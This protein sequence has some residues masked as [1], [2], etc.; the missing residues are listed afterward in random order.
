MIAAARFTTDFDRKTAGFS[1]DRVDALVWAFT[2]LLV[3]RM[4]GEGI[5]ELYRQRAA[6]AAAEKAERERKPAP[7][8]QP[9]STEWF[10]DDEKPPGS[11]EHRVTDDAAR[12]IAD[13]TGVDGQHA[14]PT[15]KRRRQ[16]S[17]S[18][19]GSLQGS[20]C[21]DPADRSSAV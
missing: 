15:P 4:A 21:S 2:D 7:L 8:P 16:R 5:Y 11:S 10:R 20:S 12:W 18:T 3:E 17:P 1:P 9:G 19:T 13:L 14:G 6:K